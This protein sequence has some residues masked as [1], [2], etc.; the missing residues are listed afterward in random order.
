MKRSKLLQSY[1]ISL[2]LL[3]SSAFG[4]LLRNFFYSAPILCYWSLLLFRHNA[5]YIR[6]CVMNL[7][8]LISLARE[9]EYLR[10][11]STFNISFARAK[12]INRVYRANETISF[13]FDFTRNSVAVTKSSVIKTVTRYATKIIN[14]TF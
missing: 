10:H 11:R 8:P 1:I 3:Y 14:F 5:R 12:L 6:E 2:G 13:L 7:P 9:E 4:L